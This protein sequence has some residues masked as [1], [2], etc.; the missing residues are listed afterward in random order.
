[1]NGKDSK[2]IIE[3]G[4]SINFQNLSVD[5]NDDSRIVI[6]EPTLNPLPVT[7]VYF[8]VKRNSGSAATTTLEW[9]TASEKNNA[10]FAVEKSLD[11]K[12][13]TEAG[14]VTGKNAATGARYSFEDKNPA[15]RAYYRLKQVDL[16]GTFTYSG[17]VVATTNLKLA[18][19]GRN[20]IFDKNFNGKLHLVSTAG[21]T[22]KTL[23]LSDVATFELPESLKGIFILMVEQGNTVTTQRIRM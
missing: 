4:G 20:V 6:S 14:R 8:D 18:V 9:V 17:I 1:M 23:E 5:N 19:H 22:V 11:V 2:L 7:L 12:T 21:I 15:S 16:D 3:P 10:Y 13:F